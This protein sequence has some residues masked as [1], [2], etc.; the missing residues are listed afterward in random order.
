MEKKQMTERQQKAF[1]ELAT[2]MRVLKGAEKN[3]YLYELDEY[4]K[5]CR[6]RE[7]Y[8]QR[9]DIFFPHR[10]ACQMYNSLEGTPYVQP[11]FASQAAWQ[12]KLAR[13]K[14]A[15]IFAGITAYAKASAE[16]QAD[17]KASV[18]ASS[19]ALQKMVHV[20]KMRQNGLA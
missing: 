17:F 19:S 4:A 3:K 5:D 8:Q 9:L 6:V 1:P 15:S 16:Q 14:F 7:K 12:D 10:L 18:L 20:V 13:R 2:K 11:E